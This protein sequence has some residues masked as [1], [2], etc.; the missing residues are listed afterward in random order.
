M[1]DPSPRRLHARLANC[2]RLII[3]EQVVRED[4]HYRNTTTKRCIDESVYQLADR[5]IIALHQDG[6]IT[7]TEMGQYYVRQVQFG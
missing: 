5:E 1:T 4:W 6:S 7:I 2:L 3:H